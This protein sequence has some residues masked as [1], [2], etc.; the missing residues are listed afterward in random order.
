MKNDCQNVIQRPKKKTSSWNAYC[1]DGVN[2]EVVNGDGV[3]ED[4]V[5]GSDMS[6]GVLEV[7]GS[8]VSVTE[9]EMLRSPSDYI[10]YA[11]S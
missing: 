4:G 7:R 2:R 5:E 3:D 10:T 8:Y 6:T 1:E 11:L 9:I